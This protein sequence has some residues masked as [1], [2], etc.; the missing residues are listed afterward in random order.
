MDITWSVLIS[1]LFLVID[2]QVT[3][4]FSLNTKQQ[5]VIHE[6]TLFEELDILLDGGHD[7]SLIG[8]V[9]HGE[10]WICLGNHQKVYI[11]EGRRILGLSLDFPIYRASL[12]IKD[13]HEFAR[14]FE[15]QGILHDKEVHWPRLLCLHREYSKYFRHQ[16]V[17]VILE[18]L[19]ILLNY[20]QESLQL[21][22]GECLHNKLVVMAE[23][24]EA[25]TSTCSFSCFQ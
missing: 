3:R 20:R 11:F 4:V 10:S 6:L 1:W 22:L 23:E 13:I 25:S 9:K 18:V 8:S 12:Q 7:L 19:C 14:A 15:L 5:W 21:L 2:K 24:E 17:W 16:T